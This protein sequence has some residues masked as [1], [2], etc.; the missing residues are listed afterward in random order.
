MRK[1]K[2]DKKNKE[3]VK[4]SKIEFDLKKAKMEVLQLGLKGLAS[5]E[6]EDATVRMLTKLGAKPPKNKAVN[7]KE[8]L[9][10][11]Q[12]EKQNLLKEQEMRK[13]FG[14]KLIKRSQIDKKKM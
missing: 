11:K 13:L 6:K 8:F 9:A 12:S 14:G 3:K 7:Y 2:K 10:K 5:D 4:K 1:E